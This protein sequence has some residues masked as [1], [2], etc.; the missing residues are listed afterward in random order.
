MKH[1][2]TWLSISKP[3]CRNPTHDYKASPAEMSPTSSSTP[4]VKSRLSKTRRKSGLKPSPASTGLIAGTSSS[5]LFV[6]KDDDATMSPMC[7]PMSIPSRPD[8]VSTSSPSYYHNCKMLTI[9]PFH[10]PNSKDTI[11]DK[12][13][14]WDYDTPQSRKGREAF[15]K[16]FEET[17]SKVAKKNEK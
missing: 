3:Y 14:Y 15:A 17:D 2:K 5:S 6:K 11:P 10:I 9:S 12:K 8:E 4:V 16:K 13:V 7:P 1:W